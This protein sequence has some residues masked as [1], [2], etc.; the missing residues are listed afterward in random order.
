MIT[1]DVLVGLLAQAWPEAVTPVN[2]MSGIKRCGIYPLN[3]GEITDYQLAPSRAFVHS[4]SGSKLA[5]DTAF[6]PQQEAL[7]E[8]NLK[9][10]M[11]WRTWNIPD[12]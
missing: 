7:F 6:T 4:S 12:D 8:L 2:A 10:G 11:I 3:P 5:E 1:A 9:K